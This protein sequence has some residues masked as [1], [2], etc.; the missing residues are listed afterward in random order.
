[1][2]DEYDAAARAAVKA[3]WG[4]H[5]DWDYMPNDRRDIWRRTAR[6]AIETGRTPANIWKIPEPSRIDGAIGAVRDALGRER[7]CRGPLERIGNLAAALSILEGV[8]DAARML[9]PA[10]VTVT[11]YGSTPHEGDMP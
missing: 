7:E 5:I 10:Q 8:R 1:M 4:S 2:I 6:A 9:S 11:T 3:H